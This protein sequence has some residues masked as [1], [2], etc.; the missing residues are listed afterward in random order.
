MIRQLLPS[1]ART[2]DDFPQREEDLDALHSIVASCDLIRQFDKSPSV[3]ILTTQGKRFPDA[4]RLFIFEVAKYFHRYDGQLPDRFLAPLR[5]H[6]LRDRSHLAT[7]NYDALLYRGLMGA[8][9]FQGYRCLTDGFR[10]TF[11]QEY[12]G[13]HQRD[14]QSYYLHLHGSPLYVNNE[15]GEIEKRRLGQVFDPTHGGNNHLVLT[16]VRHKRS[17]I[18]SSDLLS[19]YWQC[20]EEALSEVN[21]VTLFGY[22]G[23]DTHLNHLI[24]S[25][26]KIK[27][28]IVE[29]FYS[30]A[31]AEREKYWRELF[32]DQETELLA[33]ENI[34]SFEGW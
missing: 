22:G 5:E 27:I 7:L 14:R 1:I 13:R 29:S 9:V 11:S 21:L 28:R 16:A 34:L 18:D 30:G 23:G 20:F 24:A 26:R 3:S 31:L 17:V 6:V 32:P 8:E 15:R 4:I 10:R 25:S 33:F 19:A 12:L 2:G